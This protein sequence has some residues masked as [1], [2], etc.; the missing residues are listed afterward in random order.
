PANPFAYPTTWLT[1]AAAP[2][3]P[4]HRNESGFDFSQATQP[5]YNNSNI[6]S[7]A[8]SASSSQLN[9]LLSLHSNDIA[10]AFSMATNL[11]VPLVAASAPEYSEQPSQQTIA[12]YNSQ[13]DGGAAAG[14]KNI[15]KYDE[16]VVKEENTLNRSHPSGTPL[17]DGCT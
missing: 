9:N 6:Q 13:L 8:S 12:P 2:P 17:I 15:A 7:L 1:N 14:V 11:T 3:V 16:V 4:I 5:T 10:C